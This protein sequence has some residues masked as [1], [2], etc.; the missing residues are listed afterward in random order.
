MRKNSDIYTD[1]DNTKKWWDAVG[2]KLT[3]PE[4][5][6]KGFLNVTFKLNLQ[7]LIQVCYLESSKRGVKKNAAAWQR[8]RV[9]K[10]INISGGQ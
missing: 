6:K 3:L 2:E 10:G 5:S 4:G 1:D 8:Q 7:N 9:M